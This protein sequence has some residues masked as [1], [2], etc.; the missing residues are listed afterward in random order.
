M[1]KRIVIASENPVKKQAALLAFQKMFPAAA[2]EIVS[3]N[4][5]SGVSPQP[6]GDAETLQ[7]AANRAQRAFELR[8]DAD[9]WVGIEGG[10]QEVD[11]ELEAFA[12]IYVLSPTHSGKSR[13]GAFYLPPAVARLVRAG[14]ELGEADDIVFGL[15]NSK[16]ENGAIGILTGNVVDRTALYA[17]AVALALVP[18]RNPQLYPADRETST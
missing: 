17:Q 15:T 8:P 5:P 18:F 13:T 2:F 4:V 14:H 11:G 10:V 6:Y 16:Q 7:G 12:W 9:F 1:S 3:V